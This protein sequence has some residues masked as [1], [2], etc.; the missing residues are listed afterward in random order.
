MGKL[1][2]V[3]SHEIYDEREETRTLATDFHIHSLMVY[4]YVRKLSIISIK[5]IHLSIIC[6]KLIISEYIYYF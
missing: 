5:Y 3:E 6:S 1:N 4:A 2:T